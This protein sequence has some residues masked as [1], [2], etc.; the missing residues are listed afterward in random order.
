MTNQNQAGLPPEKL[1]QLL[2][3]ASRQLGT[4]PQVLRRQLES[5][6]IQQLV[7]SLDPQRA[8]QVNALM[9]DTKKLEQLLGSSQVRQLLNHLK[10]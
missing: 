1:D 5:G 8:Q 3:L 4:N 10:K 2:R 9:N 6:Q 7:A